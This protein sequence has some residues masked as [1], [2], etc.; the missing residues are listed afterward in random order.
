CHFIL[1]IKEKISCRSIICFIEVFTFTHQSKSRKWRDIMKISAILKKLLY[2][3]DITISQLARAT[4]VPRQ[5]IDNWISGQE[6]RSISQVKKVASYFEISVD[7]LCFGISLT[8]TDLQDFNEE[9]NA[10]IFE[11]VL[12]R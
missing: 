6:P 8:K 11:V 3:H 4:K 10:G 1:L 9:I 12:R 7:E 2:E 5:T